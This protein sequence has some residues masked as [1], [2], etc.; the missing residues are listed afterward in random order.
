MQVELIEHGELSSE[1]ILECF[2]RGV[3][4]TLTANLRVIGASPELAHKGS[5]IRENG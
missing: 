4:V 5:V 2:N 3:P 1:L